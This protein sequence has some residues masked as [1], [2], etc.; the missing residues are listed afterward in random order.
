MNAFSEFG[1]NIPLSKFRE[2]L[3][4]FVDEQEKVKKL[5]AKLDQVKKD[6]EMNKSN[7]LNL[8]KEVE[9]LRKEIETKSLKLE[10]NSNEMEFEQPIGNNSNF[11]DD[12]DDIKDFLQVTFIYF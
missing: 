10:K 8:L 5:A 12:N 1:E 4:N 7:N 11:L 2:V 3:N 9:L 6:N